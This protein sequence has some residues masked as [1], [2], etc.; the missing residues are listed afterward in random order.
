MI[1][2]SRQA[3]NGPSGEIVLFSAAV[4]MVK[5]GLWTSTLKL[6]QRTPESVQKKIRF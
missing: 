3:L 6:T 5:N 2:I 4:S 1:E